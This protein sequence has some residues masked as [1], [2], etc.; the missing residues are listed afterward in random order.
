MSLVVNPFDDDFEDFDDDDFDD[1]FDEP[2]AVLPQATD[3]LHRIS[4]PKR[5]STRKPKPGDLV[6]GDCGEANAP[7]RRFCARCGSTLE[8]AESVR[9]SWWRRL[10][11]HRRLKT[12]AAGSR[13]GRKGVR[14]PLAGRLKLSKLVKPVRLIVSVTIVLLGIAYTTVPGVQGWINDRVSS[15]RQK[16][17]DVV[18]P[19]F[20]PVNPVGV[21][22][23]AAVP[24]HAGAAA[25]DGFRNTYWAAPGK[26]VEPTL[27]LTF[28]GRVDLR[29]AIVRTGDSDKF[30]ASHR[31]KRLH[32]VYSTGR[33]ADV[34]LNDNP[35]PQQVKLGNGNGVTSVEIHVVDVYRSVRGDTVALSEI[36]FFAKK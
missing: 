14:F 3:K 35:D 30:Q 25:V 2:E 19:E 24:G 4:T 34:T 16:A 10:V 9:R 5:P 17:L 15:S 23:T 8:E 27:V 36:E 1:D 20:V 32:L 12:H 7:T 13:P 21:R 28:S 22:A 11:P 18:R 26:A 29:R 31:P 6:C 33:T